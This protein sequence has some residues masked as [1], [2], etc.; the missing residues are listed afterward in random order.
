MDVLRVLVSKGGANVNTADGCVRRRSGFSVSKNLRYRVNCTIFVCQV[1]ISGD[2][3]N[4]VGAATQVPMFFE[5]P[6][7]YI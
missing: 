2:V 6:G 5:P 1:L 7:P 4:I 3:G